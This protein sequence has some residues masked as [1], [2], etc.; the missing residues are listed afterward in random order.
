MKQK[1]LWLKWVLC[2]V[3]AVIAAL[4]YFLLPLF[5]DF[6]EKVISGGIFR[7]IAFPLEWIISILPFSLTEAVVV[8]CIPLLISLLTIW[9]IR[10]IKS[11]KRLI[12]IERG[13]R[14]V[15]WCLTLA[16][17]IFMIMHGG[18]YSRKTVSELMKLPDRRYTAEELY[19]LTADLAKKASS[20]REKLKEDENGCTILSVSLS[21]Y[22]LLADD[23]YDNLKEEYPFL[24]TGVWRV[25]SV[26]LSHLWSYTGTTGV[27]C[28]WIGE[29]NVNTDIPHHEIGHTA[30][31][32]IAH[33]MGFA[34]EDECNFLG[35]L[36]CSVS[37]NPDYEYSGYMQAY[38]YCSN[39]LYKAD[40]ELWKK[41]AAHRSEGMLRD[42][43]Q[44]NS[45]WESFEGEVMETSQ[46][47][48]DSFIKANGVESGVLSYSQ[49]VELMLKFYDKSG[50]LN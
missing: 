45:Y 19:T 26:A 38:I 47:F 34:K 5:P 21:D 41:A 25:K 11:K 27:Y 18:N 43:K 49:M 29:A 17:L 22:L 32:E 23:C 24:K 28:P 31:H 39:A 13:C 20:A 6:T 14:F 7:I 42:L 33:T 37:N 36:A 50:L 8:L 16:L 2:A 30:T 9:I 40:K 1:P 46:S 12:T 44:T 15:A 4:M 10:I 48:N 35:W 3:P